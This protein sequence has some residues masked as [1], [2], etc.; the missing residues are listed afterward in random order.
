MCRHFRVTCLLWFLHCFVCFHTE[1]SAPGIQVLFSPCIVFTPLHIYCVFR[2]LFTICCGHVVSL[3]HPSIVASFMP[4]IRAVIAW[5]K[6]LWKSL[7]IY[8]CKANWTHYGVWKWNKFIT[9]IKICLTLWKVAVY[10]VLC[11]RK[12][13]HWNFHGTGTSPGIAT[14]TSSLPFWGDPRGAI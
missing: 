8:I 13:M 7:V 5:I 6:M 1:R 11:H 9:I 3:C 14:H 2:A 10:T 12:L 4:N